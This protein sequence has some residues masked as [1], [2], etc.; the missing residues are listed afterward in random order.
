MDDQANPSRWYPLESYIRRH[1]QAEFSHTFC[2][3]CG[4]EHYPGYYPDLPEE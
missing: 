1:S 2:P 4:R 3:S